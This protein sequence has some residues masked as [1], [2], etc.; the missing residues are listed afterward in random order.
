[1]N[2]TEDWKKFYGG[3]YPD[4]VCTD[5]AVAHG[6]KMPKGHC[7]TWHEGKCGVC[8]LIKPVTEPRDFGHPKFPT[9]RPFSKS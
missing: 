7:A 2:K 4:Y 3:E 8:G 5:C 1:M 9:K 6:G